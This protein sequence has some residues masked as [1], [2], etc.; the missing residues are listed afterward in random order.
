MNS[1]FATVTFIDGHTQV[2]RS[3]R[4]PVEPSTC[5]V[6][7]LAKSALQRLARITDLSASGRTSIGVTQVQVMDRKRPDAL[8]ELFVQDLVSQVVDL[9]EEVILLRLVS[10]SGVLR[11]TQQEEAAAPHSAET[12]T[13]ASAGN[14]L[15][16]SPLVC[17]SGNTSLPN[18]ESHSC[19]GI[20][21]TSSDSAVSCVSDEA[22]RHPGSDE[23]TVAPPSPCS[24]GNAAVSTPVM[25][26]TPATPATA[27][28]GRRRSRDSEGESA[29]HANTGAAFPASRV[30]EFEEV[31]ESQS[32][33][34]SAQA[35]QTWKEV[36]GAGHEEDSRGYTLKWGSKADE[37]FDRDTYC[38]DPR[39]AR[40]DPS[41]VG[42]PIRARR[43]IEFPP[44]F[45]CED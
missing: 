33:Q 4:V 16:S 37:W 11:S 6:R 22:V 8:V 2:T 45:F 26:R 30:L 42:G 14:A 31:V 23:T 40:L 7:K 32:S 18:S 28:A 9:K 35:P 44:N 24:V 17:N 19:G 41:V 36:K 29:T 43:R 25:G 13:A 38:D 39:K 5:T 3:L 34:S 10:E 27:T 15:S 20:P 1:T 21:L 12:A